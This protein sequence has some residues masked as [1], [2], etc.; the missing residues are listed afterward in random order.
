MEI[1]CE[2]WEVTPLAPPRLI[3]HCPGCN[4]T[5]PFVCAGTFRVNAQQKDARRVAQL[6]MRAMRLGL[7]VP[8]HRTS[9][10][11]SRSTR[12]C[13]RLCSATIRSLRGGSRSMRCCASRSVPIDASS[14]VT[15][16]RVPIAPAADDVAPLC[17]RLAVPYA[18]TIRL[19]QLLAQQ[20]RLSRA[21]LRNLQ[22]R[23]ELI[24][25][26]ARGR[27]LRA[28][29]HDGQRIWIGAPQLAN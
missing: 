15:V 26:P 13:S 14:D 11:A 7:E 5:R 27:A 10:G 21:A 1:C 23:G 8:G 25:S 24:V 12:S 16:R 28:A 6:S 22:A 29:I 19:D 18:C 20:L 17:I 4:A 3:R 9:A 2:R